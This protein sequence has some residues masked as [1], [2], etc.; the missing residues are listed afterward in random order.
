MLAFIRPILKT[1]GYGSKFYLHS[2]TSEAI[3]SLHFNMFSTYAILLIVYMTYGM[4]GT[5]VL[6]EVSA[7]GG[8]G[9]HCIQTVHPHD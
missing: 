9:S 6:L 7:R 4:Y 1:S 5:Q 8:E 2:N 3:K